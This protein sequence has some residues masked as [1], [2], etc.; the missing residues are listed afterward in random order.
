MGTG[1][2]ERAAGESLGRRQG[3]SWGRVVPPG[4]STAEAGAPR[5][6][7][8]KG[9]AAVARAESADPAAPR[10][11]RTAASPG[12]GRRKSLPLRGSAAP[13]PP[14]RSGLLRARVGFRF[15]AIINSF[16]FVNR[17]WGH[18]PGSQ[19]IVPSL[20]LSLRAG[21]R[22]WGW[23]PPGLEGGGVQTLKWENASISF[24]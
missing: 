6:L 17:R 14:A 8:D 5:R 12:A 11:G 16:V 3:K 19:L 7:E 23:G 15:P 4:P 13:A 24:P 1:K 9:G 10:P 22:G 18:I 2:R 20:P 21:R